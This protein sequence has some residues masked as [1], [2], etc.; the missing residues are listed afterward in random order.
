MDPGVLHSIGLQITDVNPASESNGS[1]VA[2]VMPEPLSRR[3]PLV[4][5][6]LASL[7][8]LSRLCLSSCTLEDLSE[9]GESDACS[10]T[11]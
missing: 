3:D 10:A 9:A 11:T 7:W 4:S 2:S 1:S 6:V 5:A 8:L